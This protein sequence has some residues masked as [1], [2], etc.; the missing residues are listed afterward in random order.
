MRVVAAGPEPPELVEHLIQATAGD[1]LHGEVGYAV[2]LGEAVHGDDVRVLKPRRGTGLALE[3][4]ALVGR[5]ERLRREELQ[6]HV[7]AERDL[8]GLVDDAHAAAAQ[9]AEDAIV[10]EPLHIRRPGRSD[11]RIVG[12]RDG[13][14]LEHGQGGEDLEDLLG[15]LGVAV[16]VLLERRPLAGAVA[17]EELLG[18]LENP[19]RSRT[20]PR[21]D[22]EFGS[23]PAARPPGNASA[24]LGFESWPDSP[25]RH[26]HPHPGA[27][28]LPLPH[29]SRPHP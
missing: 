2:V 7:A 27:M 6:R 13:D 17:V 5:P 14:V 15:A 21:L 10:A 18:Q 12:L 22:H 8:L 9:L 19:G 23:A 4:E 26:R 1:E 25:H 24:R 20:A 28:R 11:S 29:A 3:P 16:G